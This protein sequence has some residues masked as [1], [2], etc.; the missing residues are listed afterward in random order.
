MLPIRHRDVR[1][2]SAAAGPPVWKPDGVERRERGEVNRSSPGSPFVERATIFHTI[3]RRRG[4]AE[5]GVAR[6]RSTTI[7]KTMN[8]HRFRRSRKVLVVLLIFSILSLPACAT[9]TSDKDLP[10]Y[11][12]SSAPAYKFKV[13][14]DEL[15]RP[16]IA[17]R[18]VPI[19]AETLLTLAP[20]LPECPR[21]R[22]YAPDESNRVRR[23]EGRTFLTPIETSVRGGEGSAQSNGLPDDPCGILIASLCR[24][25]AR[26]GPRTACVG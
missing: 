17:W 16:R 19:P 4:R 9:L 11:R 25:N 7:M 18:E 2:P 26:I 23:I 3:F 14:S 6:C 1:P 8:C 5:R 15:P 20:D 10:P 13:V 21:A 12:F 24:C 22:F